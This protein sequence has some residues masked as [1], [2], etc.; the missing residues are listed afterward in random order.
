MINTKVFWSNVKKLRNEQGKTIKDMGEAIGMNF[1]YYGNQERGVQKKINFDVARRVAEVLGTTVEELNKGQEEKPNVF[2]ENVRSR[3]M[4]LG[5]SQK[6][7]GKALGVTPQTYSY[8]EI[9]QSNKITIVEA[10][11]IAKTLRTSVEDLFGRKD[12]VWERL[13]DKAK[14]FISSNRGQ[15]IVEEWANKEI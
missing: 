6:D 10:Q 14:D 8:K 2:W 13:S 1:E 11:I 9:K 7:M 5:L 12:K 15:Q 3:R 4:A